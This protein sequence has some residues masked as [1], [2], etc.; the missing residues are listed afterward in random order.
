MITN[1]QNIHL[2]IL[3]SSIGE[4]FLWEEMA[5]GAH[6]AGHHLYDTIIFKSSAVKDL[7]FKS[8]VTHLQSA[9]YST[10]G[11]KELMALI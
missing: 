5:I 7:G 3:S 2:P 4:S 9:I 6:E 10:S 1:P 8:S 11:Q